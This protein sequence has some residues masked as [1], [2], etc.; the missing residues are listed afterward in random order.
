MTT[1]RKNAGWVA[2]ALDDLGTDG[3]VDRPETF[4]IRMMRIGGTSPLPGVI[5]G[6]EEQLTRRVGA[7]E[8]HTVL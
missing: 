5:T 6:G 2:A 3:S 1:A 4:S 7:A 8:S